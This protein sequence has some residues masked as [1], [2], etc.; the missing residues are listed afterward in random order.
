MS[1]DI[2]EDSPEAQETRAIDDVLVRFRHMLPWVS[3]DATAPVAYDAKQGVERMRA[4]MPLI[5]A[6]AARWLEMREVLPP[7]PLTLR[8]LRQGLKRHDLGLHASEE[9][10]L[11]HTL[12]SRLGSPD[13]HWAWDEHG[14]NLH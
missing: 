5:D 9:A 8:A 6:I 4:T 1:D 10:W 3:R 7:L 11:L 2:D 14:G 13:G 12:K